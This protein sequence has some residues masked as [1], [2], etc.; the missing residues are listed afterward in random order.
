MKVKKAIKVLRYEQEFM[1]EEFCPAKY[2]EV[3]LIKAIDTVL[4]YN[5]WQSKVIEG[6]TLKFEGMIDKIQILVNDPKSKEAH[7]E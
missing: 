3:Q 7:A 4:D 2:S 5:E 6:L 1:N